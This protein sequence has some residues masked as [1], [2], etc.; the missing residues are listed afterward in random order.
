MLQMFE[1]VKKHQRIASVM[2]MDDISH[3]FRDQR[4]DLSFCKQLSAGA[5]RRRTLCDQAPPREASVL[6]IQRAFAFRAS[7]CPKSSM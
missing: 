5:C 7:A 1:V 3:V 4:L 6:P 2:V